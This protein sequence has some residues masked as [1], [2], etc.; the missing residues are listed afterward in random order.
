MSVE[1]LRERV[2][3]GSPH[4]HHAIK[5]KIFN[6]VVLSHRE[7]LLFD[8]DLKMLPYSWKVTFNRYGFSLCSLP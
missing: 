1:A 7:R 4:S 6:A 2:L 3:N 5:G 8:F